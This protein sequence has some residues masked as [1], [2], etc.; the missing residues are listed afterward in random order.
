MKN[1]I[2]LLSVILC[3]SLL[4]SCEKPSEEQYPEVIVESEN[5]VNQ[6]FDPAGSVERIVYINTSEIGGSGLKLISPRYADA[7]LVNE[8]FITGVSKNG[9][10]LLTVL[11]SDNK[12]RALTLST[13]AASDFEVMKIDAQSTTLSLVFVSPGI[14][15]IDPLE[16]AAAIENIKSLTSFKPL[17]KFI[18][19]NL[20]S[21]SLDQLVETDVYNT[22]LSDCVEEYG[23]YK[24]KGSQG[25]FAKGANDWMNDFS[26]NHS[27]GKI[28]F[29]NRGFR[30]VRVTE[31]D[32][33]SSNNVLK[34]TTVYPYMKG[35]IPLS[36]GSILTLS[37]LSPTKK[38][39]SYLPSASTSY[40][41]FWIAGM[42]KKKS[43]I[44]PPNSITGL[45]SH[46]VATL[47]YYVLFPILDL[48]T[49]TASLMNIPE[50][51]IIRLATLFKGMKCVGELFSAENFT[52]TCSAFVNF[53]VLIS[54]EILKQPNTIKQLSTKFG[55]T[56]VNEANTFLRTASVIMGAGNFVLFTTN[57]YMVE[58]YTRFIVFACPPTIPTLSLPKNG[59][60]NLPN[61]VTFKWNALDNAD[62]Y[63]LQL[64]KYSN[65]SSIVFSSKGF[66]SNQQQVSSLVK[67]V[68]Y[69][70]HVRAK[71]Q[72]GNSL[73]SET[74]SF[75]K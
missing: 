36:W 74:W 10:Q 57:L 44:V 21:K 45:A 54:K 12:L 49:G 6:N 14:L 67:G 60:T 32:R 27:N 2:K 56:I 64:S 50:D 26:V 30:F 66:A 61:P 33:S 59:S 15:T 7:P 55:A 23:S 35:G 22:L 31:I 40:S 62:S 46:D 34:T 68:K 73:W 17:T 9:E 72:F 37:Y 51:D 53:V 29:K 65:F 28:E 58:P 3:L 52:S 38:S 13:P 5:S 69:Y 4:T 39:I 41:E 19:N 24:N 48:T 1:S 16:A 63:E 43:Q 11:D 20:Q 70:W 47:L 42:G 8:S 71:N 25:E 75:T 18:K